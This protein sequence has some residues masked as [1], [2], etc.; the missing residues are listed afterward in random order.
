MG[1][2]ELRVT[3]LT[4]AYTD[5]IWYYWRTGN[6]YYYTWTVMNDV[7]GIGFYPEDQEEIHTFLRRTH[8]VR[9]T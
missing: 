3:M 8:C 4:K 6:P 2:V 7:L 5:A 9:A 1:F